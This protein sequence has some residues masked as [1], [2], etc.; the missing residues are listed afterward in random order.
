MTEFKDLSRVLTGSGELSKVMAP[1]GSQV[2]PTAIWSGK[3][4]LR[5]IAPIAN[6]KWVDI[7]KQVKTG[8]VFHFSD[9]I[10]HAE[11]YGGDQTRLQI[12]GGSVWLPPN[13]DIAGMYAGRFRIWF[14]SANGPLIDLIVPSNQASNSGDV[15]IGGSSKAGIYLLEITGY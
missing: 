8:V 14:Q 11:V 12:D 3:L 15:T 6:L 9:T 2:W 5:K 13:S 7:V 1:D 10:D 4:D